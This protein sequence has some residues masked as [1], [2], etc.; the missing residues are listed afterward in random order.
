KMRGDYHVYALDQRG[1]GD[2]AWTDTYPPEAM[3]ADFA[4]FA[5]HLGLETFTLVGHSMGGGVAFRYAAEHPERIARLIIVDAALPSPNR[6][7]LPNRDSSVTR[8]LAQEFYDSEDAAVA[9]FQRLNPRAAPDRIRVAVRQSFRALPD[10]R[11][12]YKFDP[13]LRNRL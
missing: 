1:H 5:D 2:S 13:K 9:H 8:S 4:A 10:G 12:T 11:Y 3:P 6:P 7:P